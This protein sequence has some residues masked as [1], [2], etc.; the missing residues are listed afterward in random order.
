MLNKPTAAK[1]AR[2]TNDLR[3]DTSGKAMPTKR[4]D[5]AIT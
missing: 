5:S 4:P 2:K 1:D 3:A